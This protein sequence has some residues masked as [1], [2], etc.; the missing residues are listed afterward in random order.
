MT[1]RRNIPFILVI[2]CPVLLP[3][4]LLFGLINMIDDFHDWFRKW[5]HSND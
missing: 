2:L 5:R 3:L 1:D 4:M